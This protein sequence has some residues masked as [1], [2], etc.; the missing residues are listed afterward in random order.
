MNE[1]GG[2]AYLFPPGKSM[3][4]LIGITQK[5]GRVD[6]EKGGEGPRKKALGTV[7]GKGGDHLAGERL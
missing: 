5:K 4:S 3:P 2:G 7:R 6:T 1:L